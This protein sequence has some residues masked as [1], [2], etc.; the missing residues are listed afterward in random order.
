MGDWGGGGGG[1]APLKTGCPLEI[2]NMHM[3]QSWVENVHYSV[4]MKIDFNTDMD[5]LGH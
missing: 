4:S 5:V 2:S 3:W 1:P